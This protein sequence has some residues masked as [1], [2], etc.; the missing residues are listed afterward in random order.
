MAATTI[1]LS[2]ATKERLDR[3]RKYRRE[4]YDE[5]L[6]RV[7]EILNLCRSSPEGARAR[8]V[9]IDKARKEASL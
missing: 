1:K 6:E 7:L 5:V 8:L 2:H 3:L 4:T 9:G